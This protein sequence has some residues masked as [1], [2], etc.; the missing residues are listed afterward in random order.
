MPT[1]GAVSHYSVAAVAV[2]IECH[3]LRRCAY[4][5][6]AWV[7]TL[8]NIIRG[9]RNDYL[10]SSQRVAVPVLNIWLI[11]DPLSHMNLSTSSS[12]HFFFTPIDPALIPLVDFLNCLS[13][14]LAVRPSLIG[15][16]IDGD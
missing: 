8:I 12:S 13:V 9:Q 16:L 14:C 5:L 10:P 2:A 3:Q 6:F 7:G 15:T 11:Y 4:I 1:T